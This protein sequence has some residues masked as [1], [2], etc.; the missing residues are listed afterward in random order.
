MSTQT[1]SVQDAQKRL[2][3]LI[4]LATQGDEIVIA[5]DEQTRVR[6]VPFKSNPA[7]RVFGQYQ[8]KIT[9]S[10]DFNEPMPD[11]FWLGENL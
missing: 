8:G 1:V 10:E 3:E 5:Q 2:P 6:L 11:D 9:M 4:G 7:P